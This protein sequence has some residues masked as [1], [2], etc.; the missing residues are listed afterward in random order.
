MEADACDKNKVWTLVSNGV[1]DGDED[2]MADSIVQPMTDDDFEIPIQPIGI[3]SSSDQPPCPGCSK[4]F[5][6]ICARNDSGDLKS[7]N[8]EECMKSDNCRND[9]AW[10]KESDGPCEGDE[11]F[12]NDLLSKP[13]TDDFEIPIK[14]EN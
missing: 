13:M 12:M 5:E 10:T 8:S 14:L 1:C 9:S 11:D 6:P 7:F 4:T 2:F 3:E